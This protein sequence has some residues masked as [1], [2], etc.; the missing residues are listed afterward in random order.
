MGLEL[1]VNLDRPTTRRS[2]VRPW[3]SG[4]IAR[5]QACLT[6][7]VPAENL[8]ADS[9]N[10]RD[11]PMPLIKPTRRGVRLTFWCFEGRFYPWLLIAAPRRGSCD[12]LE[13]R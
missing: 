12:T 13:G 5:Q 11:A 4:Q 3:N 7:P 6:G 10:F 9:C 1:K 2:L 8:I